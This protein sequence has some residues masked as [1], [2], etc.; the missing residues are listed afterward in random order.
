MVRQKIQI[1]TVD[2]CRAL[3]EEALDRETVS[4]TQAH[5]AELFGKDVRTVNEHIG[6]VF[7]EGKLRRKVTIRKFQI[8]RR[9]GKRQLC[10]FTHPVV[11][12]D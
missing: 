4:L 10:P 5:N 11:D 2:D 8:V 12:K 7:V 3:L 1:F 6:N 9:E